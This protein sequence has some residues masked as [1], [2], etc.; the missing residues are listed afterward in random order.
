[1]VWADMP[2]D[3][4][5][6]PGIPGDDGSVCSPSYD[7]PGSTIC[8]APAIAPAASVTTGTVR[9]PKTAAT[10][11]SSFPWWLVLLLAAAGALL[12]FRE[13]SYR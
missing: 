11:S 4:A 12:L 2:I 3:T 6:L 7:V 10:A 5:N 9:M 8:F 13:R 1:M